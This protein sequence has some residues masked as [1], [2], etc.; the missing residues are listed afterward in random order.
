M[1]KPCIVTLFDG[2]TFDDFNPRYFNYNPT[3][4][5]PWSKVI[6]EGNFNVTQGIQYDRTVTVGLGGVNIYFGTTEEPLRT[7]AESW[8]VQ[9]DLTDYS[10]LF[11]TKQSG[12]IVLYNFVSSFYTGIIYG[13]GALHFY[14]VEKGEQAPK[15]PDRIYPLAGEGGGTVSLFNSSDQLIAEFNLPPN[16]ER[17]YLDVFAQSQSSDEFWFTCVPSDLSNQLY[18]CPNTAF[19]ET[20]ISIDDQPAGVAP[21]FPWIYTGSIDPD[22]WIPIPSVQTLNFKPYRVDLTPFAG[23]L[24]N[25]NQSHQI[26]LQVYNCD[27]YFSV[28]ASLLVYLDHGSKRVTGALVKNDIGT[29]KPPV[30][31]ETLTNDSSGNIIQATILTKA[32]RIFTLSGYANTSH[33]QVFT[34]VSQTIDFSN[35]QKFVNTLTQYIQNIT[36]ITNVNSITKTI[37]GD[38]HYT[39]EVVQQFSFPL[40]L[41][42]I[43]NVLSDT[44]SEQIVTVKQS[45]QETTNSGNN[46]RSLSDTVGTTDTLVYNGSSYNH[47]N[48]N[49]Y[50]YLMVTVN[51]KCTS[52][53]ITSTN[54]YINIKNMLLPKKARFDAKK[55]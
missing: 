51:G 31:H 39:S 14:P 18:S 26:A 34:T 38:K 1:G 45:Y 17:V 4:E 15:V 53:L 11:Y 6:F 46:I 36:Q 13:T 35:N 21:V 43:S 27:D 10:S 54:G 25:T 33:G 28:V 49:S 19:R 37:E 50:E 5:G 40:T 3:C 41:D 12:E 42:Y 9:R 48:R 44:T 32:V 23:V 30:I 7:S 2:Y 22:L 47:Y 8:K 55:K 52:E 24:S 29:P 16:I 20:E